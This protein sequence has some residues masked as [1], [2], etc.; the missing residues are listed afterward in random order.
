VRALS[1]ILYLL[2][3]VCLHGHSVHTS[4]AE[5][6]YNAETKRLEVSLTVFV[7][8]LEMALMRQSERE[9]RLDKTPAAEFDAQ[10][11]AYLKKTFVV[12]DAAG[13]AGKM[14]WVGRELEKAS[15]KSGDPAVVLFF[16]VEVP[17]GV[18]GKT[19]RCAVFGELFGD[20]VNLLSL[21]A[22]TH[23]IELRFAQADVSKK[24]VPSE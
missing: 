10:V 18:E 15:E 1:A 14:T 7:S 19:L 13:K 3:A 9:M 4:T 6:E 22:G 11:V 2:T 23:Q 24:L 12:T 20:Q 5:A 21:R 16:E 17:G 8:D